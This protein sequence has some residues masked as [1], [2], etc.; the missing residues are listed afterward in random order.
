MVVEAEHSEAERQALISLVRDI[1]RWLPAPIIIALVVGLSGVYAQPVGDVPATVA[2][3]QAESIMTTEGPF[4]PEWLYPEGR[5]DYRVIEWLLSQAVAGSVGAEDADA[6]WEQLLSP[7]DRVGI[8]VD[9]EGIQ[10]H[11]PLLEALVRQIMDRGVPM[12]NIIIYAGEE[13]ALFRAGYDISGRAPGV[14]VMA[15]DDRGYRNGVTRIALDHCTKIVNLT[16]LRVDPEVGLHGALA[17][18]LA[19]VPYVDRQRM[20]RNPEQLPEA[21]AI[22]TMRRKMVLHIVDA[23]RPGFRPRDGGGR[24][25]TWQLNGVLASTD[26]VAVDVIGREI[27]QNKLGSE[28]AE[29]QCASIEVPYLAPAEAS[30]RLGQSDREQIEVLQIGP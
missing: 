29:G 20:R 26:P 14:Q 25:D 30:F 28:A 21:A 19:A 7:S 17:N 12:R 22:A 13:S 23:L 11:D 6:A 3:A 18:C 16:R 9:V 8:Q 10:P 27:L 15:S 2:F 4:N 24:F 5:I 1:R